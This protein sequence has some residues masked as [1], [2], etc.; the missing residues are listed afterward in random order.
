M[1]LSTKPYLLRA[2]HD[3]CTDAGF[4]PYL[5]VAVDESV[6]VPAAFVKNGE[7]VLNISAL[8]TNRLKLGNEAVEFSARFGGVATEVYVPIERVVAIYARENGQGMAFEA[9]RAAADASVSSEPTI[10]ASSGPRAVEAARERNALV[11]VAPVSELAASPDDVEPPPP[12]RP[13]E[14]PRLTRIK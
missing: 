8:A 5:A 11:P 9:P 14:R 10:P 1:E 7:I 3:W 4:T 12:P 6:R 13:G 2:I